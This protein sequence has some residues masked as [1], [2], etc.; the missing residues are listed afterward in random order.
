VSRGTDDDASVPLP[1]HLGDYL[2]AA[3]KCAGEVDFNHSV[4]IFFSDMFEGTVNLNCSI[5]KQDVDPAELLDHGFDRSA[6]VGRG[7]DVRRNSYSASSRLFDQSSCLGRARSIAIDN[8]HVGLLAAK[9]NG[10]GTSDSGTPSGNDH[11]FWSKLTRHFFELLTVVY[12]LPECKI[13]LCL[14]I[15]HCQD[16]IG[17]HSA[18]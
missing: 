6:D 9:Q 15:M 16:K 13:N 11:A 8:T 3:Q 2:P 12:C 5:G 1:T 18:L 4:P 14:D 10:C 17:M 7:A